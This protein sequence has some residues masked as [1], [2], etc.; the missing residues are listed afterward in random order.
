LTS[1]KFNSVV[2]KDEDEANRLG[3]QSTPSFFIN[4]RLLSGA[5]PES[6]FVR[7]IEDELSKPRSD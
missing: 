1:G 6:A 2:Q 3:I 4:G 7:I 5:Q